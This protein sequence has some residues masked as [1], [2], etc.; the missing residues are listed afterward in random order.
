MVAALFVATC[1]LAVVS[2]YTTWQGMALYLAGWFSVLAATGIQAA[3]VLVAWLIG[4]TRRRTWLL[5]PVYAITATV[6]VAFS[7]VSLYTWFSAKERPALVERK[8]YDHLAA[9]S[10]KTEEAVSGAIAEGR[11]HALA[12]EEMAQAERDRGFL[13]R[14]GDADPY[15]ASIRTQVAAEGREIREGSGAGPRYSAFERFARLARQSV[16]QLQNHQ[17]SLAELRSRLKPLDP[18]DKQLRDFH[19]VYDATPWGEIEQHLHK[20]KVERPEIGTY[21]DFV[22]RTASGQED[23]MQAFQGLVEAPTSRHVFALAL[24]AFIDLVIFLLAYASGPYLD[25]PPETRWSAAAAA[26]ESQDRQVFIRQFLRKLTPGPGGVA[27][28]DA[29][30]LTAGEQRF[31]TLLASKGQAH[32]QEDGGRQIYILDDG[33]H[34][35]LM[36]SLVSPGLPLRGL[37]SSGTPA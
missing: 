15:L 28:V 17:R 12:L 34:E 24:A 32:L 6:S 23:L 7:Y 29:A 25:G 21:N 9:A 10:Q 5:I 14:A 11:K 2:W 37:R 13:S 30:G 33:I 8:L 16:E 31:C 35:S 20:G 18:S 26:L 4:F 1:L 36:D 3:L 19:L 22:D 27:Q